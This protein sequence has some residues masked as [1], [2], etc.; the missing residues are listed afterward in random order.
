MDPLSPRF[1]RL[2][3]VDYI[4]FADFVYRSVAC[5]HYNEFVEARVSVEV[6]SGLGIGSPQ[7]FAV[8]DVDSGSDDQ[9]GA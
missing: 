4:G 2:A 8:G 1:F 5:K 6:K 3:V 7:R 9:R